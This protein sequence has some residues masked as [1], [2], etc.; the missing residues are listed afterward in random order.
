MTRN[1]KGFIFYMIKW[2]LGVVGRKIILGQSEMKHERKV[3]KV[4]RD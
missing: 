4:E 2:T 1:K 3:M